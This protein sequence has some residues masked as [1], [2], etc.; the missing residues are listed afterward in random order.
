MTSSGGALKK[1]VLN[2]VV[3]LMISTAVLVLLKLANWLPFTLQNETLRRYNSIEEIQASLPI[4]QVYVPTY[5][6]QTIS[7]PP[8][9]L[10]AQSK[11][12]PWVLM[13][14][15]NR[16]NAR[17][18][19]IIIQS[20]SDNFSDQM[21]GSFKKIR[22]KAPFDLRGRKSLLE[23]GSCENG[24]QCSRISWNEGEYRLAI[25]MRSAPFELIKIAESM[26]H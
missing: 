18:M 10:F 25:F 26:L 1:N 6:P 23:V 5:F 7:W 3:F 12:F 22:E 16:E 20:K 17:E 8:E 21:P 19:L 2:F 15:H 13:K 24:E 14:F 4:G 9:Y 11:P